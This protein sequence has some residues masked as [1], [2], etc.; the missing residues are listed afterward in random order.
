MA[1]PGGGSAVESEDG[2]YCFVAPITVYAWALGVALAQKTDD[3]SATYV[4]L[5]NYLLR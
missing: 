3:T 2:R 1:S 4:A 5:V